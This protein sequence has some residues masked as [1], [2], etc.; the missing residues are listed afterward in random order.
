MDE[1]EFIRERIRQAREEAR[2]TQRQMAKLLAVSQSAISDIERGR[3][4]ISAKDLA[5]FAKI[6]GKPIAYFYPS[7]S[8]TDTKQEAELLDL[9]RSVSETWQQRML[10]EARTVQKMHHWLLPYEQAGIPEEFYELVWQ[11]V[12]MFRWMDEGPYEE[13]ESAEPFK[14]PTVA[15]KEQYHRKRS[16][17]LDRYAKWKKQVEADWEAQSQD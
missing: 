1:G 8:E 16:E 11:D 4:Q 12:E 7:D 15:E 14:K 3:V 10:S 5:R 17:R 2:L 9:F 13:P 6:L